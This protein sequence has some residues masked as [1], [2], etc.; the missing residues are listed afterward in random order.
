MRTRLL[1]AIGTI[2]FSVMVSGAASAAPV[3]Y[4][5]PVAGIGSSTSVGT[6]VP[7][8]G[9]LGGRDAIEMYIPLS[10]DSSGTYGVGGVG[11][12]VD[13]CTNTGGNCNG[14]MTMYL[15]FEDLDGPAN[16]PNVEVPG[17]FFMRFYF[18][19]LDLIGAND[20]D[21]FLESITIKDQ[22]GNVLGG[23]TFTT[24]GVSS[25]PTPPYGTND[26]SYNI[27]D[28]GIQELIL[29]NVQ[30]PTDPFYAELVFTATYPDACNPNF[31]TC[32]DGKIKQYTWQN[33]PE[34]MSAEVEAWPPELVPVPAA[35][36]LF[37]SG[38]AAMGFV[39]ARRHKKQKAQNA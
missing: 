29:Y 6:V 17:S 38:L 37:L 14:Y 33:T 11:T 9:P 15:K 34:Y 2:A 25:V 35:L 28:S 22:N 8:Y 26:Y 24:G 21:H 23:Q 20:P 36:P 18:E 32:P 1:F 12:T 30:V 39:G 19:D 5:T 13:Y 31:D 3:V 7:N 27:Q 4:G 10:A 16:D